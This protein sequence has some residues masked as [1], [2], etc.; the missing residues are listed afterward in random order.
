[1]LFWLQKHAAG[2]ASPVLALAGAVTTSPRQGYRTLDPFPPA[3]RP[4]G[5]SDRCSPASPRT[6]KPPREVPR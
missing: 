2:L 4:T 3:M 5:A 1:M 6:L